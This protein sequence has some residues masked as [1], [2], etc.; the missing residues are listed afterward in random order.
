[1]TSVPGRSMIMTRI[2]G[3]DY[4]MVS[5]PTCKTCQS[6]HRTLIENGLIRG[7]SFASLARQVAD[8]PDSGRGCPSSESIS[9]HKANGHMPVEAAAQRRLIERRAEEIGRDIEHDVE[10]LADHVTVARMVVAKGF[11]R[12]QAGEIQPD[13]ADVLAASRLLIQV[14]AQ[15]EPGGL[16][17]AAMMDVLHVYMEIARDLIPQDRWAEYATRVRAHPVILAI[18]ARQAAEREAARSA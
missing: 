16:D 18:E 15:Q 2:G 7:Y 4:P 3:A 9:A 14:D 6:P 1:M 8:L 5:I 17:Q 11:E 12:M 10:T 13:I